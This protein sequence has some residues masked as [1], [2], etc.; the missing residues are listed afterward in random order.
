MRIC[1]LWLSG[2]PP[3]SLLLTCSSFVLWEM[4]PW[5]IKK[6][7]GD[8]QTQINQP[9]RSELLEEQLLALLYPS[10]NARGQWSVY[11]SKPDC[12]LSPDWCL[13]SVLIFFPPFS[14]PEHVQ[15]TDVLVWNTLC[16]T[17]T[18]SFIKCRYIIFVT[19]TYI[20][21]LQLLLM[22]TAF[23]L[24]STLCSRPK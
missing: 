2:T 14:P 20:L 6:T 24:W 17:R 7:I 3:L 11:L 18:H 12:L 5:A 15:Q 10:G 16:Y 23:P 1:V 13:S 4:A 19:D 21:E 22:I 8:V 9:E